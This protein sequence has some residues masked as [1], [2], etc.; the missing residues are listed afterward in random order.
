M[1]LL[2]VNCGLGPPNQISW[3]RLW[4]SAPVLVVYKRKTSI[5][6]APSVCVVGYKHLLHRGDKLKMS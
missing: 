4:N 5:A 6:E 1:T 3:L 2:R